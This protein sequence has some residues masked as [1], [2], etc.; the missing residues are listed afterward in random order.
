LRELFPRIWYQICYD[1]Y[2]FMIPAGGSRAL[3]FK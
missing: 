1:N 3:F 2:I